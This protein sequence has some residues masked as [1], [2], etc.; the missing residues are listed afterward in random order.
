MGSSRTVIRTYDPRDE[1]VAKAIAHSISAYQ[2]SVLVLNFPNNP[3]GA[4]ISQSDLN[5]ILDIAQ[6]Y[7]VKVISDEVYRVFSLMNQPG[8]S[9]LDRMNSSSG[10]NLVHIDSMSKM[11]GL[12]GL[13]I[14]FVVSDKSTIQKMQMFRSSYAS[15]VSSISQSACASILQDK[16][17]IS[18]IQAL[19]S[20]TQK[21]IK[22]AID[23]LSKHQYYI[24]SSGAVYVW[25]KYQDFL[26][27]KAPSNYIILNGSKVKVSPGS[28]FGCPDYFRV[29]PVRPQYLLDCIFN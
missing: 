9:I 25:A 16:R 22:S 21:N 28:I 7:Q 15:C 6:E 29:C 4:E 17:L 14:G 11:L 13:R 24:E 27:C 12:G 19:V 18:Q 23:Q 5:R 2:P 10:E 8:A 20:V 3:T 26:E 1:N